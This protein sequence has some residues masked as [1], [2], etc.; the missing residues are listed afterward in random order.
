MNL[1]TLDEKYLGRGSD[2]QNIEVVKAKGSYVYDAKGKRFIDFTMGWCVGNLGWGNDE[3]RKKLKAFNGPDYVTPHQMYKSWAELGKLLA[4]ITPGK[5]QKSFRTTSGTES[6]EIALQAAITHTG[7]HKFIS[8]EGAYH[9]DSIAARSVGSPDFGKW[10]PLFP[11][12]RLSPPLNAKT[13]D[14]AETLL[15]NKDIAGLIMEPVICNLNVLIPEREFMDRIQALCKKYGT[16]LIIDE[17]ATG[18][19]RTGKMFACEHYE[20]E[21]DILCL[22]KSITAGFAPMGATVMTDAVA[23]S[24]HH[25]SPYS[26][27]G[28]HPRSVEAALATIQFLLKYKKEIQDNTLDM[29]AYF[30]ER[31]SQMNFQGHVEINI[32]GL[33]IGVKLNSESYASEIVE[34]SRK[35]GLLISEGDSG[36]TLFPA[37]DIDFKTAKAGL[38]ILEECI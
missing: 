34:K 35:H 36:F 29:G 6:V 16:L 38:D 30:S 27:Y 9:G 19:G 24:L 20:L 25:D 13:A 8:V 3:I 5:L 10:H 4:E 33:A 26:T 7:R 11:C 28:W 1:R 22:A 12:Y 15:K 2:P 31:L 21:P 32:M 23:K 14:H 18:F 17:V 37:L